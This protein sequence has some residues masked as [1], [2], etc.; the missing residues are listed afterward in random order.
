MESVCSVTCS[1]RGRVE[2]RRR[3]YARWCVRPSDARATLIGGAARR[4]LAGQLARAARRAGSPAG[5]WVG[6]CV[7]GRESA[8]GATRASP[9]AGLAS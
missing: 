4:W 1:E 3:M 9:E 6:A 2:P 5:G 8:R 7:G